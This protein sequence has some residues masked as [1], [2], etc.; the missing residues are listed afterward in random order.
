MDIVAHALWAGIGTSIYRD[1]RQLSRGQVATVIVAT[2]LPDVFHALP[3]AAWALTQGN[4]EA[5]YAYA[6]ATPGTEPRLPCWLD[7][8]SHHIHC[9]SHSMLVAGVISAIL[10]R[11]YPLAWVP[12]SGWWLHIVID[13]PTH[14]ADFYPSPVLYP[15]TYAGLDGV[16]WNTP[17]FQWANYVSL[18]VAYLWIALRRLKAL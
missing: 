17:A 3:V 1:R 7:A 18:L 4:P 11:Y 8:V 2:I 5:L 10:P 13:A 16:A 14:T 9:A 12:L 6:V 15:L